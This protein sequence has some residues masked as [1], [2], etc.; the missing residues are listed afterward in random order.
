MQ[1]E[2]YPAEIGSQGGQTVLHSVDDDNRKNTQ[3]NHRRRRLT[4][5]DLDH[6]LQRYPPLSAKNSQL[7][8]LIGLL[9][10]PHQ[11]ATLD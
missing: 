7:V 8:A 4:H 11:I 9:Q 6:Q 2:L 3:N 10:C 1:E 5:D